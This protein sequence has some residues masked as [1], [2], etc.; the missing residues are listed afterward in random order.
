MLR[1]I[2]SIFLIKPKRKNKIHYNFKNDDVEADHTHT[3][4]LKKF[5]FENNK[6]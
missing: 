1:Y 6:D 3:G 4:Q 2:F 5:V